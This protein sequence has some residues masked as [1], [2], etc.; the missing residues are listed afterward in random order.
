LV[1]VFADMERRISSPLRV[2][3]FTILCHMNWWQS[4]KY[5]RNFR[6]GSLAPSLPRWRS[7]TAWATTAAYR[8]GTCV[9]ASALKC[10]APLPRAED[11][12]CRQR[13]HH[14][15]VGDEIRRD[16]ATPIGLLFM[17]ESGDSVLPTTLIVVMKVRGRS[18]W[19]GAGILTLKSQQ[20]RQILAWDGVLGVET[21]TGLL[22][23]LSGIC[24]HSGYDDGKLNDALV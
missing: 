24:M 18:F 16:R 1:D 5:S 2:C 6:H 3:Y 17:L 20:N 8:R 15:G 11:C 12:I 21:P 22:I 14:R 10:S 19:G 4:S 13:E 23:G 7:P 9:S